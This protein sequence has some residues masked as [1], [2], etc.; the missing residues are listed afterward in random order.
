V[1]A[2]LSDSKNGVINWDTDSMIRPSPY[3]ESG[4]SYRNSCSSLMSIDSP[5]VN[6]G[7]EVARSRATFV[8]YALCNGQVQRQIDWYVEN[9]PGTS[10]RVYV[11]TPPKKP[12]PKQL[13][14]F[15]GITKSQGYSGI[16]ETAIP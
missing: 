2:P 3:Y 14:Q 4:K 13:D 16:P 10:T 12:D 9:M 5:S 6:T 11:V 1:Y 8:T 15:K 7:G